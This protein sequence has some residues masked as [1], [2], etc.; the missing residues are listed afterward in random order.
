MSA[1]LSRKSSGQ[2]RLPQSQELMEIRKGILQVV[3]VISSLIGTVAYF[4]NIFSQIRDQSWVIAAVQTVVYA[5]VLLITVANRL[6]YGVRV[7]L[8]LSILMILSVSDLLE[9]GLAGE[10]RLFLMAFTIVSVLLLSSRA[11]IWMFAVSVIALGAV[12]G[13]MIAGLIP[14]PDPA[15]MDNSATSGAWL[16]GGLIYVMLVLLVI[17]AIIMLIRRLE[18]YMLA[19]KKLSEDLERERAGL[20]LRVKERT[21]V[22]EKQA[23][24]METSAGFM[25]EVSKITEQA[26]LLDFTIHFFIER[27]GIHNI[28]IGLNDAADEFCVP[29]R[30]SG[31]QAQ[32]YQ[33]QVLKIR[34]RQPGTLGELISKAAPRLITN[35]NEEAVYF[36]S[37][38]LAELHSL[39]VIPLVV[40]GKLTGA[41][42]L[43]NSVDR[44]TGNEEVQLYQNIA[45]HLAVALEKSRLLSEVSRSLE[46]LKASSRKQTQHTW[47]SYL[48]SSRQAH[49]YHYDHEQVQTGAARS[50][51]AGQA[52]RQGR[53]VVTTMPG[54]DG[55]PAATVVA[56]PIFLRD[57]SIGVIDIRFEGSNV[58]ADIVTLIEAA[59]KRLAVALDNARLMEQAQSRAERE[60]VVSGI[61]SQIR[62]QSD[63]D[64]I[65]K[66]A[67]VEIGRSLGVSEVLVQ[68]HTDQA[69]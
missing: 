11:G 37:S 3:L 36:R 22:L 8:L 39:V 40:N 1:L 24:L 30:V 27:F 67:A 52:V 34:L 58:P 26:A 50:E 38:G 66:T 56:V 49:S 21:A 7:H 61:G 25:Q 20:E 62:S 65:L 16:T 54:E 44:G 32:T 59:T 46:E 13:L 43:M 68:L 45:S 64:S 10:G 4:S 17:S 53:L 15:D 63:I 41:L 55:Q 2:T 28:F 6:P 57:H 14:A 47:R 9:S 33:E 19:Q 42:L 69:A 31:R 51:V 23:A 5:L 48:R 29:A 60:H 35:A 12:A 18:G